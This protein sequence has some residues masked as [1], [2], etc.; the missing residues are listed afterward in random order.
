MDLHGV[1][2]IVSKGAAY[3]YCMIDRLP[4]MM[5]SNPPVHSSTATTSRTLGIVLA[6]GKRVKCPLFIAA[7][8]HQQFVRA[9]ASGLAKEDDSSVSRLWEYLGVD[10][11]VGWDR[12]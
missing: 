11:R 5:S 1:Y 2:D 10:V 9:T 3:S 4:R 12:K 7:A 6:E 8:A